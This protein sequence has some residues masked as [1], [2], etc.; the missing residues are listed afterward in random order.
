MSRM[1][2]ILAGLTALVALTLA[3]V[4]H[5][6]PA[7]PVLKWH[8][9]AGSSLHDDGA[10]IAVDGSGNIY[11]AGWSEA[12][13]GTPISPHSGGRDAFV[14][15]LNSAGELQWNTFLG[16]SETDEAKAI[17]VDGSGN[18]YVG[19]RSE[20]TW[21][22]PLHAIGERGDAFVARLNS[23][24]LLQWNLFIGGE[25]SESVNDIAVDAGGNVYVTGVCVNGWS[26]EFWGTP[27]APSDIHQ[28]AWVVKLNS[29]GTP[30]WYTFLGGAGEEHGTG[31]AVDESGH[32]YVSGR[33]SGT[34]GTPVNEHTGDGAE[35]GFAARLDSSG[36][37]QW[38]T[39]FGGEDVDE[40]TDVAVDASGGVYVSGHS[41]ANWGTPVTPHAGGDWDAFAV[42]LDGSG[43]RQWHTFIGSESGDLG[44]AIAVDGSRNTYVTGVW[45]GP[46]LSHP[47]G[48]VALLNPDGE[49]QWNTFL[50]AILDGMALDRSR[51]V[52]VAGQSSCS[53]VSDEGG[54]GE[55]VSPFAGGW[56]AF[57][58][59]FASTIEVE[60]DIKPGS[61]P[62]S[63]NLGSLGSVPVAILSTP[64]FDASS[65]KPDTVTLAGAAVRVNGRGIAMASLQDVNGDGVPDLVVHV[66]TEALAVAGA[67]DVEVVLTGLTV[68]GRMIEGRDTI[69]VI[70]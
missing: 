26:D 69:R 10:S 27:V 44:W 23:S 28:N 19:G 56:D 58:A 3:P 13:W 40:T 39:F 7:E 54:R 70:R 50:E 67:G 4:L 9:Y 37:R 47:G 60:I 48:F 5:G 21:G 65:V 64:D 15:K 29:S 20:A 16:S 32:V 55:P 53:C 57:A 2:R 17:A 14:A 68:D 66:I 34:W 61:Q 38:H 31:I 42:K 33:S 35:D 41:K 62:N 1:S 22:A 52:H 18:V 59:R 6:T 12:T 45:G 36:N 51:N 30:A 46:P 25:W 43:V 63:V 8:T 49:L 11:L 24:G